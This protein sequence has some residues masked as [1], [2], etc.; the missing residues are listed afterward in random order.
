MLETQKREREKMVAERQ[1]IF[2]KRQNINESD[3]L[4]CGQLKKELWISDLHQYAKMSYLRDGCIFTFFIYIF[5][6]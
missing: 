5:I 1:E 2:K 3:L 6:F 4:I